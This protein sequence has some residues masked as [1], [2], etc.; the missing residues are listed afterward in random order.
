MFV[1]GATPKCLGA[2][3]EIRLSEFS[4]SQTLV[5]WDRR[6]DFGGGHSIKDNER[7]LGYAHTVI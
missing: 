6:L 7:F 4:T 2:Y 1:P 5:P 3:P